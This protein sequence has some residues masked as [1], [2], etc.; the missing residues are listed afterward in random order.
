MDK[1]IEKYI[2]DHSSPEDPVLEELFR[3]T[4]IRFVNPNMSTG[5]I[6]GKLLELIS[7]MITPENIQL[8]A[9]PGV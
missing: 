4:H 2:H 8:F 3:E 6:Q 9:L 1:L 7:K 5:H